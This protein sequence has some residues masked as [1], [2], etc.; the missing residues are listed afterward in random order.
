MPDFD[1]EQKEKFLLEVRLVGKG[2]EDEK[3][4][5]QQHSAYPS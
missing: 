2:N 4:K 3:T 5:R 1:S